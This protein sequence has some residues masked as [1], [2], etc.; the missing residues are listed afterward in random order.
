MGPDILL[1]KDS[2]LRD[3]YHN[4]YINILETNKWVMDPS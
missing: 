3:C 2:N 4:P 1:E